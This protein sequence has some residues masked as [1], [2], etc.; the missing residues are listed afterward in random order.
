LELVWPTAV[1]TVTTEWVAE[2]VPADAVVAT[3][4]AAGT[5]QLKSHFAD[6]FKASLL[7]YMHHVPCDEFNRGS[8]QQTGGKLCILADLVML[9]PVEQPLDQNGEPISSHRT[10]P[11]SRDENQL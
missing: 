3:R 9:N 8:H 2:C 11:H 5:I 4:I 7:L 6:A 1:A 10:F